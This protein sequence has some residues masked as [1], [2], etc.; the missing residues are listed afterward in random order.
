MESGAFFLV[1]G[2]EGF[3][4]SDHVSK[5]IRQH[6]TTAR[7]HFEGEIDLLGLLNSLLTADMFSPSKCVV[8]KDPWFF[9]RA[10]DPAD[11]QRLTDICA[12]A[13][14]GPHRVIFYTA[15]KK[16]DMRRKE[17][18]LIKKYAQALEFAPFKDWETDKIH[19]WVKT[20]AKQIG[21]SIDDSAVLALEQFAGT[22]LQR[23][24]LELDTLS[25]YVGEKPVITL[26]DVTA[27][28]A[29]VSASLFQFQDALRD[30]N[31]AQ[32]MAH[33]QRLM[34][35]GEDPIKLIGVVAS[36]IR[37][38]YQILF[39]AGKGNTA[40]KIAETL[41]KHPF[42]IG[43]LLD[44]IKKKHSLAALKSAFKELAKADF[45]IKTGRIKP[46]VS[47]ELALAKLFA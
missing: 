21:K 42:Y 8:V 36:N 46:Q 32:V 3:L 25:V 37:L 40:Q 47:L 11:L 23:L 9:T 16:P 43:K 45:N 20:R 38:Y 27:V 6:P 17:M 31:A 24:A 5:L 12:A 2:E 4:V 7:E 26:S 44:A 13:K 14:S 28:C 41:K 1:F 19:A 34:S 39:L 22:Q 29:G 15:G 30:R 35:G 10:C 33:A 18:T